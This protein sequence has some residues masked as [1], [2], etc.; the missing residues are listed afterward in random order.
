VQFDKQITSNAF[1]AVILSR[2]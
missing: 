1:V 2:S